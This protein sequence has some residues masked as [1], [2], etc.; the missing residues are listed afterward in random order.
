MSTK[1]P[2]SP[3][4]SASYVALE[5]E[6]FGFHRLDVERRIVGLLALFSLA[7]FV[8][9]LAWAALVFEGE[10]LV[11]LVDS[12]MPL[13]LGIAALI[14]I[15]G[16]GVHAIVRM[17][18]LRWPRARKGPGPWMLAGLGAPSLLLWP[19]LSLRDRMA[20]AQ[21]RT[22]LDKEEVELAFRE[23]LA[24]PR[25]C[26]AVFGG[27]LAV[28][29]LLLAA[30]VHTASAVPLGQLGMFVGLS[31]ASLMPLVSMVMSRVR[32]FL[33]PELLAAPRPDPVGLPVRNSLGL[34][35][36]APAGLALLGGIL[37]PVL[38]GA[39]W[40]QRA[41]AN[42]RGKQ[43]LDA[44]QVLVEMA[45]A[46]D[47]QAL[48]TAFAEHPERGLHTPTQR[49]GTLPE[50]AR[51]GRGL[52]DLDEDGTLDH[53]V[54]SDDTRAVFAI[55]PLA[56]G[57][58]G[59][60]VIGALVLV[61][62]GLLAGIAAL[63]FLL[64]DV[65]R[66]LGRASSQ[67]EILARGDIPDP[68][69]V[70]TFVTAELRGLIAAMNRLVGRISDTNVYKYVLIEKG[71]EADR[72]KSKFLANM[73]HDLRS[74]LNSVI[75]FSDLMLKGIDGELTDVQRDMVQVILRTGKSLL[76]QIDDILDTAKIEAG[77]MELAREPTPPATLIARAIQKARPRVA[78]DIEFDTSFGAGLPPMFVDSYR[79]TQALENVLIFASEGLERGVIEL[80]CEL[81]RDR[82][83]QKM[84]ALRIISPR[85]LVPV[86][87]LEQARRGFFRLPGT[88]GLGLGLPI[89]TAIVELQGGELII[90]LGAARS[91]AGRMA[92]TFELRLPVLSMR[93][94]VRPR[95]G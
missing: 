57:Q 77:K 90:E 11:S 85:A 65:E 71:Q 29:T 83:G 91:F 75:G 18:L 26:A 20:R 50:A 89:A 53:A 62:F 55:V 66:D 15:V 41:A 86:E 17:P 81:H 31:M 87:E 32:V 74:P 10:V 30:A 7:H 22:E 21:A 33:V 48:E 28:L 44:A 72:L 49:L 24:T 76:K 35:L 54:Y 46:G 23:L 95:I 58:L 1:K 93:R 27:W 8:W 79:T 82:E 39:L 40:T 5:L 80:Y 68:M 61:A 51:P 6:M 47:A 25:V 69:A 37:V 94:A 70:Q 56:E 52:V 4:S 42:E 13:R 19:L 14:S 67:V 63:A 92:M 36:G 64:R 78:A 60:I 3:E 88:T 12:D 16:L 59:S 43:G 2:G 45:S 73:S 84:I 38:M 9:V 34:R